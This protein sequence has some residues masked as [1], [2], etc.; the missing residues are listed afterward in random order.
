MSGKSKKI[1]IIALVLFVAVFVFGFDLRGCVSAVTT[2][3]V[4]TVEKI[5][6]GT[7]NRFENIDE[8]VSGVVAK[9]TAASAL[10][11]NTKKALDSASSFLRKTGLKIRRFLPRLS[12]NLNFIKR[13]GSGGGI[14]S[15]SG[16]SSSGYA[17][18]ASNLTVEQASA[19]RQNFVNYSMSL[20]GVPYVRGG[21]STNGFDCS[22]FVGYAAKNGI[23]VQ[24][25][26]TASQMYSSMAIVPS[27]QREPGDLV[28]FRRFGKI[29]HVG[30][31]LGEYQGEGS[32]HGRE[33][34]INSASEGPRT[35]VV[36]S[37]LDEPYWR[38]HY[39]S[40]GRFLPSSGDSA[41][42]SK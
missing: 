41:S 3:A 31:Y 4:D 6:P 18:D 16:S 10:A 11:K 24:L 37:A 8:Q 2:V 5:I 20:R 22:G 27:S 35:G 36:V 38:T 32:L 23:G 33:I 21:T 34:F 9:N 13:I 40:T 1:L 26:R 39:S 29:D 28:F 30:I 25:P 12:Y 19:L 42:S 15:S 7:R 17:F 14:S